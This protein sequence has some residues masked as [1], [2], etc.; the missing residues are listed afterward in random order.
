VQWNGEPVALAELQRRLDSAGIA[1]VGADGRADPARQ[2]AVHLDV[3]AAADYALAAQVMA[4][5][6]RAGLAK[7]S[8]TSPR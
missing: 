7:L 3:D 5:V 6:D 1:S 4:R 2:P 8:L